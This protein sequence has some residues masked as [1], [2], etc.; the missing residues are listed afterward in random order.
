MQFNAFILMK[1]YIYIYKE[2]QK[3]KIKDCTNSIL[4]YSFPIQGKEHGCTAKKIK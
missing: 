4:I 3:E 1:P 2:M